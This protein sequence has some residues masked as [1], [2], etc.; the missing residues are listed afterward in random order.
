MNRHADC[1]ELISRLLDEDT[2]LT[3][4]E[5]AALQAHIA[6]CADCAAVYAAFSALSEAIGED[7]E[8][9]P[10][11]L[12]ENVMADIRREEIRRRNR[13]RFRWAGV[14]ATAAVLALVIG[15]APRLTQTSSIGESAKLAAGI[16]NTAPAEVLSE[17]A[18]SERFVADNAIAE[19]EEA[20]PMALADAAAAP[21]LSMDAVL[22]FLSGTE[23]A[24]T[25][26]SAANEADFRIETDE[27]VLEI[28]KRGGALC[29]RDPRTGTMLASSR[30]EE[31]LQAF[32]EAAGIRP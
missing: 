31:A 18:V 20:A 1:Q 25:N 17:A 28:A 2:S 10:A 13:R 12:R 3:A 26:E 8:E 16:V 7:L 22:D 32:L 27:G 15:F 11:S 6:E 24:Q 14:A 4:E 23:I 29:Y 9:P 21:A 5:N 19:A 30:S